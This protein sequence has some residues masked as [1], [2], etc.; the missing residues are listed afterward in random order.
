MINIQQ[1]YLHAASG[2]RLWAISFRST[3]LTHETFRVQHTSI[4]TLQ[5]EGDPGTKSHLSSHVS[6]KLHPDQ[7]WSQLQVRLMDHRVG[8]PTE[9]SCNLLNWG[10]S[11]SFLWITECI[12]TVCLQYFGSKTPAW[13]NLWTDQEPTD[14][15]WVNIWCFYFIK[16]CFMI[17]YNELWHQQ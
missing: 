9:T 15:V 7:K 10:A 3:S 2:W 4:C 13:S 17:Y 5:L 12:S 1:F 8:A 16:S 14:S 6:P 11:M